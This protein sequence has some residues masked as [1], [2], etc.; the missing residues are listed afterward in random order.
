MIFEIKFQR[1]ISGYGGPGS[2]WAKDFLYL[3]AKDKRE[4]NKFFLT[5]VRAPDYKRGLYGWGIMNKELGN[6][7]RA[8]AVPDVKSEN[9][10]MFS[11]FKAKVY[12]Q[13][14]LIEM[15]KASDEVTKRVLGEIPGFK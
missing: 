4:A 6:H 11:T 14:E 13:V 12:T 2:S 15:A 3:E 8:I 9:F 10:S 5:L 7:Y 1:R